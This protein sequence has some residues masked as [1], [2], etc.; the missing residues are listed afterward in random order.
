MTLRELATL[1]ALGQLPEAA[2]PF[3]DPTGLRV[4]RDRAVGPWTVGGEARQPWRRERP[5]VEIRARR[6]LPGGDVSL[7]AGMDPYRGRYVS[8]GGRMAWGHRGR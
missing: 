8:G 7:E 6:A 3:V 4:A 1:T 5:S 2:L